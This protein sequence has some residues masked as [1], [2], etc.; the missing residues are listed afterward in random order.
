MTYIEVEV[1]LHAFLTLLLNGDE[2]LVFTQQFNLWGRES[3]ALTGQEAGMTPEH[4]RAVWRRENLCPH[5]VSNPDSS[6]Q[7]IT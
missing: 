3:L 1:Q 4:A 6:V 5:W 2:W 7:F